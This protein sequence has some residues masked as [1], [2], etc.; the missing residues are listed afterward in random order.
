MEKGKNC[1]IIFD[2]FSGMVKFLFFILTFGFVLQSSGATSFIKKPIE[3]ME[4]MPDD[5]F[6]GEEK[7]NS[8]CKKE[9][10]H[11]S[12]YEYFEGGFIQSLYGEFVNIQLYS[13]GFCSKPFLPPRY[14]L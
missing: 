7:V 11:T 1:C 4:Q 6:T 14:Q 10:N 12:C 8:D 9:Q 2:L 13:S 3:Q 5:T